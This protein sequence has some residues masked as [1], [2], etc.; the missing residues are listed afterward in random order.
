MLAKPAKSF[1]GG[2]QLSSI[3]LSLSPSCLL[4]C[5][6]S[7]SANLILQTNSIG[8]GAARSA[9][10]FFFVVLFCFRWQLS[11]PDHFPPAYLVSVLRAGSNSRK[12]RGKKERREFAAA[13]ATAAASA[14]NDSAAGASAATA[15]SD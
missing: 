15:P 2:V 8:M 11:A 4:F 10:C 13:A 9:I 5:F 14:V 3:R 12:K 1:A 6:S 7:S